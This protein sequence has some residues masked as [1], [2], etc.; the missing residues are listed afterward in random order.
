MKTGNPT[1]H[2]TIAS[3]LAL[4]TV[5]TGSS[6]LAVPDQ[7]RNWEK[8][9]GIAK[10]GMNDCGSP[11]GSHQ[12]ADQATSDNS[13]HEWV[14]VPAGTCTKIPGR[15]VAAVKPAKQSFMNGDNTTVATFNV[16]GNLTGTGLGLRSTHINRVLAEKPKVT[17]FEV[18]AD[19][20]ISS[21]GLIPEQLAAV[22]SE[23]MMT[24]HCVAMS[25]GN[26]DPHRNPGTYLIR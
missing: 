25:L 16:P 21:G 7:P 14:N 26:M 5:M 22:R 13:K 15:S 2:T 18:L 20:H 8:C 1:R 23:Y 6:A 19:N 24:L 12:S 11:N 4:D 10:A 3:V 17:W 9:A